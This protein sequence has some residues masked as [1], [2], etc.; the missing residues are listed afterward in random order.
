MEKQELV[1]KT[2]IENFNPQPL[3]IE[4]KNAVKFDDGRTHTQ[5]PTA[6]Q[7]LLQNSLRVFGQVRHASGF[8]DS[9][10]YYIFDGYGIVEAM[11]AVGQTQVTILK[12]NISKEDV[13]A[14][15]FILDWDKF[16]SYRVMA[17]NL[18]W[19]KDYCRKYVLAH[20]GETYTRTLMS[21]LLKMS[22]KSVSMFETIVEHEDADGL[23]D[24]MDKGLETLNSAYKIATGRNI[25][26]EA[27]EPKGKTTREL[28]TQSTKN[29]PYSFCK[30]CPK[31][32]DALRK[33]HMRDIDK[34]MPLG[35]HDCPL[36]EEGGDDEQ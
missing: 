28:D 19:L 5:L 18:I 2:L 1:I 3:D 33:F 30:D 27:D 13:S 26:G 14:V 29:G 23:I 16:K 15:K 36:D 8:E 22:E 9:G 12:F 11:R 31:L 10:N 4:I 35:D 20:K 17:D 7:E 32:R 34:D 24:A 25:R 21:I 6:I